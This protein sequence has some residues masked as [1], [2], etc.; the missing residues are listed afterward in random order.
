MLI[1]IL[2]NVKYLQNAVFSF[3]KFESSKSL[4]LGFSQWGGEN[5]PTTPTPYH[6]LKNLVK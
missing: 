6:Y 3:E 4:L 1:L 2:I 5:L